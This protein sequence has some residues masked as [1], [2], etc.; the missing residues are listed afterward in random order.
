M[1]LLRT[2]S[3]QG[4][5]VARDNTRVVLLLLRFCDAWDD[6]ELAVW[7]G[8]KRSHDVSIPDGVKGSW[9]ESEC[10]PCESL[11]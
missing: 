8:E 1:A 2:A 6:L 5:H 9:Q 3:P 10:V 11:E 7:D 4:A